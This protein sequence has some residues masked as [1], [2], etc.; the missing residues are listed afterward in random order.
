LIEKWRKEYN[1]I[2]PHSALGYNPPAPEAI[3]TVSPSIPLPGLLSVGL[4]WHLVQSM[5]ARHY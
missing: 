5:G 4:K 2:R 3:Q 1:Q